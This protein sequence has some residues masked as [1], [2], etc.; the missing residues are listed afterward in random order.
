[1]R[2]IKLVRRA[3]QEVAAPFLDVDELVRR[4]VHGIDERKRL[5]LVG[6]GDGSG[7]VVD[8]SQRVGR[9]PDRQ[10]PRAVIGQA[11]VEVV[12]VELARLRDHPHLEDGDAALALE[13]PAKD[14]C[15]RDGRAR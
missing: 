7:D 11:A 6:H 9:G 15:W 3:R 12:P 13:R 14:R 2:S 8:R 5:G 10:Q 4:V 1:M